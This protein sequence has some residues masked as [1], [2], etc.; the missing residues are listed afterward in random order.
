MDGD[1]GSKQLIMLEGE[2][3]YDA[4][5][6]VMNLSKDFGQ[7]GTLWVTSTRLCWAAQLQANYN[8]SLPYIQVCRPGCPVN[9]WLV[10]RLAGAHQ[11]LQQTF[12]I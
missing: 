12:S 8:C 3:L 2:E 4:V 10:L 9:V 11:L 7:L 5:P 6:G 1:D